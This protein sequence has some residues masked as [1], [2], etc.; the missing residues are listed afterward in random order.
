MSPHI[1][2]WRSI[3][4]WSSHLSPGF[5]SGLFH[6]GFPTKPLRIHLLSPIRATCHANLIILDLI[7]RTT[8]G[9]EYRLLSFSL[10]SFLHYPVTSPLLVPNIPPAPYS[11]TPS[12]DVSPWMWMTKFRVCV[13]VCVRARVCACV[14]IQHLN[15]AMIFLMS[16]KSVR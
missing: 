5:P 9:K 14:Y 12:A 3:L 13:R 8:L 11:Q 7:T 15:V 16:S 4:M 2:S 1:T 6:L 10:C